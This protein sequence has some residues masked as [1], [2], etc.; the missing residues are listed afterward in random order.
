M[1]LQEATCLQQ[2]FLILLQDWIH[3]HF[4]GGKSDLKVG[5]GDGG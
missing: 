1:K 4:E 3:E 5:Q 2:D